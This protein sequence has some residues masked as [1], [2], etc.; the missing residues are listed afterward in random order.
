M[1]QDLS[2]RCISSIFSLFFLMAL[3]FLI[4]SE[5]MASVSETQS[6]RIRIAVMDLAVHGVAPHLGQAAGEILRTLFS[7][8]SGLDVVERSQIEAIAKEQKLQMSGLVDESS[9]VRVGKILGANYIVVGG[10]NSLGGVFVLTSRIVDVERSTS[11][12]GFT[13]ESKKGESGLYQALKEIASLMIAR[14][15]PNSASPPRTPKATVTPNISK[16]PQVKPAVP[17]TVNDQVKTIQRLLKQLGYNPGDVDGI[18]GPGTASAIRAFQRANKLTPDGLASENLLKVLQDTTKR[19]VTASP[20]HVKKTPEP[21]AATDVKGSLLQKGQKGDSNAVLQLGRMYAE[22]KGVAVDGW[23]AIGFFRQAAE[24]GNAD[25]LLLLYENWYGYTTH[26]GPAAYK[27]TDVPPPSKEEREKY[28]KR[29]LVFF[30]GLAE[31]GNT[32]AQFNMAVLSRWRNNNET[33]S[34]L[35]KAAE[36]GDSE[37]Q[38]ILGEM[39][40]LGEGVA[41]D[42]NEAAKWFRRAAEK[43]YEEAFFPLGELYYLGEGVDKNYNE[44]AKWL[45]KA[46]RTRDSTL[47]TKILGWLEYTGRGLEKRRPGYGRYGFDRYIF[48]RLIAANQDYLDYRYE[49]YKPRYRYCRTG[50]W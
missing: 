16:K 9:A 11:I 20:N 24:M 23:R 18:Y 4:S 43:E 29:L 33:I 32:H 31:K 5:A 39:Y 38:F 42:Y 21:P 12:L 10:V 25:A 3:S 44:A 28:R 48:E 34:W 41:K 8:V 14:I 15:T 45:I 50:F 26:R 6:K 37:S 7:E 46:T 49:P 19:K 36:K 13:K 2:K 17:Q 40:Y 47:A 27:F 30:K 35:Q 22:G 1:I